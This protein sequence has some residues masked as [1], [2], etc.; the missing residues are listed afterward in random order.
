MI[1][2]KPRFAVHEN[3]QIY[4][5]DT[6]LLHD[7]AGTLVTSEG[8]YDLADLKAAILA[9][10]PISIALDVAPRKSSEQANADFEA[11]V[12]AKIAADQADHEAAVARKRAR[13][14]AEREARAANESALANQGAPSDPAK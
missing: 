10:K 11:T 6:Q 1:N 13:K 7:A 4:D 9:G 12:K 3:G 5:Y 14:Q 8:V 2:A